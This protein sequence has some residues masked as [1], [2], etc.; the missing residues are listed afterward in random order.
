MTVAQL[1][2]LLE[3]QDPDDEVIFGHVRVGDKP[4][5]VYRTVAFPQRVVIAR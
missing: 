5:L 1:M 4:R 3:K 2:A